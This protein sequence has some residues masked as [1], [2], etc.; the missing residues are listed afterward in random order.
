MVVM[1]G[2]H[3]ALAIVAEQRKLMEETK[4]D[5][6]RLSGRDAKKDDY[7]LQVADQSGNSL[8]L[9]PEE[10]KSIII[11]MSLHEKGRAALKK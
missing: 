8:D 1:V 5:A 7:F 4:A 11:A 2:N 10:K 9:P 6:A 3:E